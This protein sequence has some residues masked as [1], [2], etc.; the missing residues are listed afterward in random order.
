MIHLL[1]PTLRPKIFLERCR[2]WLSLASNKSNI[3]VLVAVNHNVHADYLN[4]QGYSTIIV[5]DKHPGVCYAG[6]CLTS[7][8][9]GSV[10]DVVV[11]ASDDFYAFEGWDQW[12]LGR[13]GGRDLCL[14]VNDR[15]GGSYQPCAV[16]I[17]ILSF[18][19]LLRLNRVLYH[20]SYRHLYSDNEL[21]DNLRDLGLLLDCR[22]PGF[23][24]FE[25]RHWYHGNRFKDHV[26]ERIEVSMDRD[27]S[28]YV[29]RSRLPVE[30]RLR[31]ST[32]GA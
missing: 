2:D 32:Q 23:P 1:W 31:V 12:V 27:K 4:N 9:C 11:F 3:S 13:L 8:L 26:D 30:V 6:Y 15:V 14:L 28:N 18:G 20:P 17:P 7:G 19:C 29:A 22:G 24:V 21:F 5:G 10:G 16:T 25:H